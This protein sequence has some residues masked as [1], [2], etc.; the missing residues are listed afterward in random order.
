MARPVLDRSDL[1][2]VVEIAESGSLIKAAKLLRVHHATAFRRLVEL[3]R[4]TGALLFERLAQ[5]YVPQPVGLHSRATAQSA[6][7]TRISRLLSRGDHQGA[8]PPFRAHG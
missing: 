1:E 2:L 5:G 6:A 8:R 3:E 7:S 4:R